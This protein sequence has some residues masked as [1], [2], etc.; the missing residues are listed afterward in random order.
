MASGAVT[1]SS[2]ESLVNFAIDLPPHNS[3]KDLDA[4]RRCDCCCGLRGHYSVQK[5]PSCSE[6]IDTVIGRDR[7][8]SPRLSLK[9]LNLIGPPVPNFKD[10]DE[11]SELRA[12]I[13]E[14][15]TSHADRHAELRV[16]RQLREFIH[17]I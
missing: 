8:Q 6:Q 12:F 11:L 16:S 15:M 14:R 13:A 10:W 3:I 1:I 2:A 4:Q 7:N 9:V 5:V 17:V